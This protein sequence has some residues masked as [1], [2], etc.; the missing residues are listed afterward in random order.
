MKSAQQIPVFIVSLARDTERRATISAHLTSL[1]IEF[2]F[3]DGVEGKALPA[4]EIAAMLA[5]GAKLTGGQVGCYLSHLKAYRQMAERQIAA[6]L[7]LEDDA[8]LHPKVAR[9]LRSDLGEAAPFDYCFLDSWSF[10]ENGP[11]FYDASK[12]CRIGGAFTAHLLSHGPLA[13]HAYMISLPAAQQRL[14]HAF[15]MSCPIDMY[16]HLPYPIAFFAIVRPK[17]AWVGEIGFSSST[18]ERQFNQLSW[19]FLKKSLWYYRL[20]DLLLLQP[21]RAVREAAQARR[22][23]RISSDRPWK[24]LPS[25]V[26]IVAD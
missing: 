2:E 17:L 26:H 6:A 11:I 12:S 22:N 19:R 16:S 4:D 20:R 21:V 18:F 1:G 14:D 3:I 5:P 15:P 13:T 7:I 10:N 9:L 24:K 8:R 23:G 25:G